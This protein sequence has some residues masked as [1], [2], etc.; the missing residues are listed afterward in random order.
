[1]LNDAETDGFARHPARVG[2]AGQRVPLAGFAIAKSH[3]SSPAK[4]SPPA[5]CTRSELDDPVVAIGGVVVVALVGVVGPIAAVVGDVVVARV[6]T[7]IQR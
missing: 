3:S 6:S 2:A 7:F 5:S 4:T 1:M